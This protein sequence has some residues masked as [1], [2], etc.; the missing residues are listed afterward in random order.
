MDLKNG[1]F[2]D[3]I[4]SFD[5]SS[6]CQRVELA[7]DDGNCCF[8]KQ[9]NGRYTSSQGSLREDLD[10]DACKVKVWAKPVPEAKPSVGGHGWIDLTGPS[11]R[12]SQF[13]DRFAHTAPRAIDGIAD[14]N[15]N[16]HSC[17]ETVWAPRP[18]WKVDLGQKYAISAVRVTNRGDCCGDRLDGFE[19]WTNQG[20][21]ASN[22]W[23]GNG[24]TQEFACI[25]TSDMV[26]IQLPRD[27][28]LT[29]CEVAVK[30]ALT[31]LGRRLTD[32]ANST[33]GTAVAPDRLA[34]SK[35]ATENL[36]HVQDMPPTEAS[37]VQKFQSDLQGGRFLE[38]SR[39]LS[40]ASDEEDGLA[41]GR[42]LGATTGDS[43]KNI[44]KAM[45]GYSHYFG[46][47]SSSEH[48][49]TDPGFMHRPL[50]KV[51]YTKGTT[52][53]YQFFGS[54]PKDK[55]GYLNFIPKKGR[56]V[57]Y[58][59]GGQS[60]VAGYESKK[61]NLKDAK[62]ECLKVSQ[63]ARVQCDVNDDN[64]ELHTSQGGNRINYDGWT[65]YERRNVR[66]DRRLAMETGE[67][68]SELRSVY[69]PERRLGSTNFK[70]PDGWRVTMAKNTVCDNDFETHQ[71]SSQYD[72]EREETW[73]LNPMGFKLDLGEYTFSMSSESRDFRKANSKY[74]KRC[75]R[76][77]LSVSNIKQRYQI[78][79]TI[80][81]QRR[82]T[83]SLW[84][85]PQQ[86][87]LTSMQYLTCSD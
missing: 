77:P 66:Y 12:A 60:R 86:K 87:R 33:V 8:G 74:K 29:L 15:W 34:S 24:E 79:Q 4:S 65:I 44:G 48:A 64:C 39:S 9:S 78:W 46:A 62:I 67:N 51:S 27:G 5:M 85:M 30:G 45:Y 13:Q 22:L 58:F 18:W 53:E 61:F 25:G 68:T 6:G 69:G 82:P 83:S 28:Y 81:L 75:T 35:N 14:T 38:S 26:K 84:W 32:G 16:W 20:R 42:S 76:P 70:V 63:C 31:D 73:S 71:M 55:Y 56:E 49:G 3:R 52:A 47:P 40:S 11:V 41:M 7:D 36:Q 72:Y 23:L 2:A 43:L 80:L 21:C 54:V 50:W 10:N 17:T 57:Q 59:E 19:I 37:I 1:D